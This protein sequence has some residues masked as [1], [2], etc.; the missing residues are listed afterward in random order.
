MKRQVN[1]GA[2]RPGCEDH[3]IAL[4]PAH[5]AH[6]V[7]IRVFLLNV[8]IEPSI[9][10]CRFAG[11]YTGFGQTIGAYADGHYDVTAFR[12][13]SN[14]IK[15]L[16]RP[17]SSRDHY[18]L[19]FRSIRVRVVRYNSHS[20]RDADRIFTVSHS[21]KL[22]EFPLRHAHPGR[23]RAKGVLK[24]PQGPTKSIVSAPRPMMKAT[25]ILP[26]AGGTSLVE[27]TA[28]GLGG[29]WSYASPGKE[30]KTMKTMK[31]MDSLFS[32]L[33]I[34]AGYIRAANP[35]PRRF[36]VPARMKRLRVSPSSTICFLCVM[37]FSSF[38]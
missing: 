13:L 8:C 15:H 9:G 10:S 7:H 29:C 22:K 31:T 27:G 25:G 4:H 24:A 16:R 5:I 34:D 33:Y 23:D 30:M 1:P 6:K 28:D 36:R 18:H 11:Q 2:G 32:L 3:R 20:A 12:H 17:G 21:I 35:V 26:W 38:L 19:W 37:L 14:P